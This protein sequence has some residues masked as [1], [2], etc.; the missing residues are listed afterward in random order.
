MLIW[1]Q[2]VAVV[3]PWPGRVET[4][5]RRSSGLVPSDGGDDTGSCGRTRED[6][7]KRERDIVMKRETLWHTYT[8]RFFPD[9]KK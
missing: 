3:L 9:I 4:C 7:Q 6:G 5:G 1:F 8:K 2:D